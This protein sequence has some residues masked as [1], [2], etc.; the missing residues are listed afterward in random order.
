MFG[1]FI[2]IAD[3]SKEQ[4]SLGTSRP[5][6]AAMSDKQQRNQRYLSLVGLLSLLV[7]VFHIISWCS[8]FTSSSQKAFNTLKK[9]TGYI[10]PHVIDML[11]SIN[12]HICRRQPSVAMVTSAIACC[13]PVPRWQTVLCAHISLFCWRTITNLLCP[14]Y[15]WGGNTPC[16]KSRMQ[17]SF[18]KLCSFAIWKQ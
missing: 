15:L 17:R 5:A 3:G 10:S 4:E 6:E 14:S 16:N 2:T 7:V 1:I 8:K 9:E 11:Q 13:A 18:N 12:W